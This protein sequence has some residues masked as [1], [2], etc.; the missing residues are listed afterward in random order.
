MERALYVVGAIVG[1][2]YTLPLL[3][4]FETD[5]TL[6]RAFTGCVIIG[7]ILCFGEL[8]RPFLPSAGDDK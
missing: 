1:S 7:T 6:A 8:I 4:T 5:S 3:S 2:L